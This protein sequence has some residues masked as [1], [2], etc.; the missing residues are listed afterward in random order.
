MIVIKSSE[1]HEY[2][3]CIILLFLTVQC[4]NQSDTRFQKNIS[5]V[6]VLKEKKPPMTFFDKSDLME[7]GVYYYPEQWPRE[8][9]KRDFENIARFGFEFTHLAEFSWTF[10]EPEEGKFDF[11]WLDDAIDLASR[12][13]LKVI[14]CTPTLCPPAWMGD[15]FPEIYLVGSNGLRREHGI[16]ANASLSDSHYQEYVDRIVT[17]IA[18]HYRNDTRIWGWQIDNEPL[19]TPDYSPSAQVAFRQWL[20][21]RYGNI[22]K[23][24][25][26]WGGSFWSTRYS[27]F[28]Q[29]LIP[30]AAMNEEDKLSPHAL[31]DF[32]RF[33]A[34]ITARFLNRQ[35]D[36][37]RNY[38]PPDQWI[39]TNYINQ[40]ISADPRRSDHLDFPTFTMYPVNGRNEM[41][42]NNFRTGNPYRMYEACDYYRSINGITGL[43]E[44]QIGQVNWGSINPQVLPGTAHMWIMQAFGGGCS[45]LCTYRYRHPLYSSEM[46][47]DGIVGPDGLT[48][49]RGGSEFVQAIKDMKVL[50]AEYDSTAIMPLELMSRKTAF[51][52]SHE[53][54]WDID[55][56]KQT[57]LWDSWRN[58][59]VYSSAVKSTGAPMDFISEN[60]DF[61]VYPFIVAPSYQ[62]IDTVLVN[63][64]RN[65]VVKG[66]NLILSCRTGQ[67]NKDSHFFEAEMSS[68][69]RTLIGAKQ[70]F[71]DMMVPE[72]K[73]TV[74]TENSDYKWHTWAE[75]LTPD[76]TTEVLCNYADQFYKGKAAAVTRYLGKGTVTYIGVVSEDGLLERKLVRDVYARAGVKI[77][78]FPKGVF[79]EWRDGFCVA[80]NYTDNDYKMTITPGDRILIGSNPLK[81]GQAIVW[82]TE[83]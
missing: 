51:L 28:G 30:N 83:K 32:Q 24:N 23:M 44:L 42:G 46:Y 29:V 15:K 6:T 60:D 80:V 39:T 71:F 12:S 18:K 20:K 38:I 47:Y 2:L 78:D 72:V 4:D 22:E 14:M 45:F 31:L 69:I 8:Q 1:L 34:D 75:I 40:S 21:E 27:D 26:V 16:R 50:R 43:M 25:S 56:Q 57:T 48:L 5:S 54:L 19:A 3:T 82:K 64:W 59:N 55:L 62:L 73:G 81:S 58:R 76:K 9:W 41:G 37:L 67:K 70:E 33:T 79:M 13:G 61:S 66:G 74:R 63:K 52:W 53:V 65:Y 77:E 11:S 35:A 36:I 10:L 68:S 17:A 7:I 49:S